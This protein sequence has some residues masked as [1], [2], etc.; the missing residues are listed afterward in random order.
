MEYPK[1]MNHPQY[2]PA[3]LSGYSRGANGKAI[4][5]PPGRPARFNPVWVNN[6]DQEEYYASMGYVPKGEPDP[7]RYRSQLI[8]EE[9]A[10]PYKH[11]D[12]P[13]WLYTVGEDGEIKSALA[14]TA[15]QAATLGDGWLSD[16]AT[17]KQIQAEVK[18]EVQAQKD[19]EAA[20]V[21][22]PVP[23]AVLAKDVPAEK[24][25]KA[26]RAVARR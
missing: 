13:C 16:L 15:E 26:R 11:Q 8:G 19:A 9:R 21:A 12:Y 24:P 20:E 3:V 1:E 17:V 23:A 4:D 6:R 18:A 14:E 10:G 7:E 5:D 22:K 2:V 25:V